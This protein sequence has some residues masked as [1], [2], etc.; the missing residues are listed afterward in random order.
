[1]NRHE[2][3][4]IKHIHLA[5]Q[6]RQEISMEKNALEDQQKDEHVSLFDDV[7]DQFVSYRNSMLVLIHPFFQ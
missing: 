6:I 7:Q 2:G 4:H 5:N 1:M 3:T